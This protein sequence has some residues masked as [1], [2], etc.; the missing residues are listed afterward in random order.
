MFRVKKI[1]T[2]GIFAGLISLAFTCTER[3][4][5]LNVKHTPAPITKDSAPLEELTPDFAEISEGTRI[6]LVQ[7][8][9]HCHQSTLASHKPGAV[10]VF[11]LDAMEQ[12]H[13]KLTKKNLEGLDRRT[14]SKASVTEKQ[15]VIIE[16]FLALKLVQ[17]Q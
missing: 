2:I 14:K 11:D 12:W 7:H 4:R 13:N 5:K 9:G 1:T 15:R 16:E 10:A 8:C 17:L 6:A 3:H